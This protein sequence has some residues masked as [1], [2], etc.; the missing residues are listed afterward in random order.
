MK[1]LPCFAGFRGVQGTM[2]SSLANKRPRLLMPGEQ[3][4]IRMF[5]ESNQCTQM[6]YH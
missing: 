4:A 3:F 5:V 2:L 6:H 1:S